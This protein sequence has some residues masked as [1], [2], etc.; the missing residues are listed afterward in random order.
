M[1]QY[2]A[3]T[4]TPDVDWSAPEQAAEMAE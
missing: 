2:A 1:S 3:L 4:Y